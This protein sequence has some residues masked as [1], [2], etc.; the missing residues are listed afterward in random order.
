M[1]TKFVVQG[2]NCV[3]CSQGLESIL[4]KLAGVKTAKVD[5]TSGLA[6]LNS[7][8]PLDPAVVLAE[9]KSLGFKCEVLKD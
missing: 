9:I 4:G 8:Q 6:I 1:E 5:L 7:E 2:M 3:G